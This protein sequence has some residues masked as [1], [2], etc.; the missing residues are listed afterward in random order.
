MYCVQLLTGNQRWFFSQ[1]VRMNFIH[2]LFT[3]RI[4][5][6]SFF[7]Q[8]SNRS[9]QYKA[10]EEII[11]LHDPPFYLPKKPD[12]KQLLEFRSS[13]KEIFTALY[14]QRNIQTCKITPI[15][16][17]YN[18]RKVLAYSIRENHIYDW[19]KTDGK[20]LLYIHGGGFVYGD[21]QT[22]SGY[23][24]YLSRE[25]R[26]PVIHIEYALTPVLCAIDD[27]VAVYMSMLKI[28]F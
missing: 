13:A 6:F 8:P 20:F 2:K 11:Y 28:D 21:I 7:H 18:G 1:S 3:A 15:T 12:K 9:S 22:Y 27:I 4:W 26:M 5:M 25:Y 19:T 10:F 14:P 24:C 23:E 17:E 16:F